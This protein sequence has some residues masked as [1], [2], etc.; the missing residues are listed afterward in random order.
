MTATD[1]DSYL[2]ALPA[3]RRGAL[4]HLRATIAGTLPTDARAVMSY[5]IPAW[6]AGPGKGKVI[7]GN[8][9]TAAHL[10]FYAF[11]GD[12]IGRFAARLAGHSIAK[13]TIRFTPE[14]PLADALIRDITT[15]RL[16]D[17]GIALP[18][19]LT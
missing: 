16:I 4:Q 12:V 14:T 5:G 10:A 2:A 7:V 8:A 15:A 17:A 6:R 19:S 18:G 3:D 1:H 13:G 9:A 11:D